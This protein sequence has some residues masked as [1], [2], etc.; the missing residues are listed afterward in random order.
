MQRKN[1]MP[2]TRFE[3]VTLGPHLVRNLTVAPPVSPKER[4]REIEANLVFR[5]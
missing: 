1:R 4:A 3:P 2:E 5:I